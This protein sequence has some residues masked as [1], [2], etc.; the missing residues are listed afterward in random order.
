MDVETASNAGLVFNPTLQRIS[1][2]IWSPFNHPKTTISRSI[3]PS[4]RGWI[5]GGGRGVTSGLYLFGLPPRGTSVTLVEGVFDVLSPGLLGVALALLGS[6]IVL[7]LQ[8]WLAQRYRRINLWLDPDT[9]ESGKRQKMLAQL[10]AYGGEVIEIDDVEP[11][12]EEEPARSWAQ[13]RANH[14]KQ[15]EASR[16]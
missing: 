4:Q 11:G 14:I 5:V 15:L 9:K 7:D 1:A 16:S 13:Y 6:S 8:V 12:A 2:P 10:R 3:L